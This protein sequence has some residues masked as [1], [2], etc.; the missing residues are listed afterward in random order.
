MALELEES[1]EREGERDP[2][3][4]VCKDWAFSARDGSMLMGSLLMVGVLESNQGFKD[5]IN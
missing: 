5:S 4:R 2:V 1:E 3:A